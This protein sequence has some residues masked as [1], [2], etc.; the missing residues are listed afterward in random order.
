MATS[1]RYR[2]RIHSDFDERVYAGL[3]GKLIGV[4][5][6][7]RYL[8]GARMPSVRELGKI[9]YDL[10]FR[11]DF[12]GVFAEDGIAGMLTAVRAFEDFGSNSALSGDAIAQTW[13]NYAIEN[14]SV[15]WWGGMGHSAAHT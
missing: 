3:L 9:G 5:L 1:V 11:G 10:A 2:S 8:G 6:G 4:G 7:R 13:F 14:R 15:L 12:S